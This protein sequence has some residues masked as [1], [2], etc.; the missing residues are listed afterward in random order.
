MSSNP[1]AQVLSAIE[2]S[3][4]HLRE[5][6]HHLIHKVDIIMATQAE[7]A[8]ILRDV[9]TQ[10]KKTAAEIAS[11]QAAMD[12]LKQTI[13][14]LE[15]AATNASPELVAAVADVKAQAQVVDDQIPDVVTPPTP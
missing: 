1:L 14:D 2:H 4:L 9:L 8:Q 11:L 6:L 13:L 12:V 3:L 15:A 5:Q 7:Q 10:Q